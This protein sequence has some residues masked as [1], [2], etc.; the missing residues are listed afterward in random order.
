LTKYLDSRTKIYEQVEQVTSKINTS[1]DVF[2]GNFQKSVFVFISFYLTVFVVKIFNKSDVST[3]ISKE[4]TFFGIGLLCLS[5]IFMLFSLFILNSDIK[6]IKEKYRLVKSRFE[7]ILNKEDVN[8]I[9]NDDTE[10]NTDIVFFKKRRF[11]FLV[12]WGITIIVLLCL[13]FFTSDYI[14]FKYLFD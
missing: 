1:L 9:L 10:F 12:L 11:R 7:D 2:L 13:L 4:A 5:V 14:N 6:R 3:A 8:K